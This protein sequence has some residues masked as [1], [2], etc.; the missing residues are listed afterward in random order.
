MPQPNRDPTEFTLNLDEILFILFRH[1]WKILLCAAIGVALAA[2]T[3]LHYQPSYES[4]AKLML[5]YVVDRSAVDSIDSQPKTPGVSSGDSLIN[6]EIEILTS[7]DLAE[8]VAGAIG[9][10]RFPGPNGEVKQSHRC[11]EHSPWLNCLRSKRREYHLC[12]LQGW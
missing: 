8:Q 1:K 3:Y 2:N 7:W 5:R 6:A 4:E 11:S 9:I 10:D 12:F